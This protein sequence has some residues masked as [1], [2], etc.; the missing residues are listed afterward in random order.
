MKEVPANSVSHHILLQS[1]VFQ[2]WLSVD[3]ATS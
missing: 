1:N 3:Q 2:I